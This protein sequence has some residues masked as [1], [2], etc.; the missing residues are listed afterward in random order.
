MLAL[1]AP[2]P[3]TLKDGRRCLIRPAAPEDFGG[4]L[5]L[6]RAIV[7]ARHGVVKH[8]D[9]LPA[10]A[11]SYADVQVRAGLTATDGTA[12]QLVAELE[13]Q[14]LVGEASI[15]RLRFRMVSH[16]GV[17][18]IGVHPEVQGLGVGRAMLEHLLTWARS[19]R[20]MDGGRVR[21]VELGVRADN[22]K[23]IELYK[24]LGFEVEGARRG[25]VRADDGTFVDSVSM[26]LMLH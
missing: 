7:R 21:K 2:L 10:D 6:E 11:V 22:L 8:E 26:A 23:A 18:G 3:V 14:G 19:H 12:C 9:E 20:D 15:V 5:E 25:L 13:G 1:P 4:L 24:A 16:V 17:L